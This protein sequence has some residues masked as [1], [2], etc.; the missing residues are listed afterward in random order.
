MKHERKTNIPR[1]KSVLHKHFS[2]MASN[3][4]NKCKHVKVLFKPDSVW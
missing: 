4:L 3:K 1:V 2:S